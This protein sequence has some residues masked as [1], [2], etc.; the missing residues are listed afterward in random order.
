MCG[1][2]NAF[3]SYYM[4][5]VSQLQY[6]SHWI[7]LAQLA[8]QLCETITQIVLIRPS[9]YPQT[10]F[11]E[12]TAPVVTFQQCVVLNR[13]TYSWRTNNFGSFKLASVLQ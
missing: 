5:L 8:T 7:G 9:G 4:C 13:Y 12:I 3:Y 10:C 2:W 11:P 1:A 6:K